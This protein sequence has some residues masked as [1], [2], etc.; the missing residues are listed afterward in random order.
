[1][2][3]GSQRGHFLWNL[4]KDEDQT[5]LEHMRGPTLCDLGQPQALALAVCPA[6]GQAWAMQ[7]CNSPKHFAGGKPN[8][9]P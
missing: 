3:R 7:G 5:F 8:K 9:L 2:N 4:V 6:N 1:M